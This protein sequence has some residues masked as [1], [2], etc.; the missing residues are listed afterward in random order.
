MIGFWVPRY[1]GGVSQ[2]W[3]HVTYGLD[4]GCPVIVVGYPD[5]RPLDVNR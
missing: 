4:F 3:L 2:A 1:R 5:K